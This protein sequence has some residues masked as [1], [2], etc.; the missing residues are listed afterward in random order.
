MKYM[1]FTL[2]MAC[3]NDAFQDGNRDR[4]VAELLRKIAKK[5]ENGEESGNIIDSNGNK[6]GVWSF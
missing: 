1:D 6:V 2:S 5:I 4:E 3:D